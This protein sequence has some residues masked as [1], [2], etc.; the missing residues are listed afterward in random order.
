[1]FFW[2]GMRMMISYVY[3]IKFTFFSSIVIPTSTVI[4]RP[5]QQ[6]VIAVNK[7]NGIH[8][9]L[10][11][12]HDEQQDIVCNVRQNNFPYHMKQYNLNFHF[13][14]HITQNVQDIFHVA[15]EQTYC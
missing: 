4:G 12:R 3:H 9:K 1:L 6:K 11:V 8:A 2:K 5:F 10:T 15:M 14:L 13:A 7:T